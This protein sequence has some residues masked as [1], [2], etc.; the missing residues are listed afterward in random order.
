MDDHPVVIIVGF[1]IIVA[2]VAFL[3]ITC[4]ALSRQECESTV[5]DRPCISGTVEY[6]GD[7]ECECSTR[8]GELEWDIRPG[9]DLD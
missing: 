9:C 7:G 5:G 1:T 6:D 8:Y 3:G 4:A 2:M